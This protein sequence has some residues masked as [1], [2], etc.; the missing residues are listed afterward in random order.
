MRGGRDREAREE[1]TQFLFQ[2]LYIYNITPTD[3]LQFIC[4]WL[5]SG[6]WPL[7]QKVNQIQVITYHG[8]PYRSGGG[9][10]PGGEILGMCSPGNIQRRLFCSREHPLAGW[11]ACLESKPSVLWNPFSSLS[12]QS[13]WTTWQR[14]ATKE[15]KKRCL[16]TKTTVLYFVPLFTFG[17]ELRSCEKY[18][19]VRN[20]ARQ[21]DFD[22]SS[23]GWRMFKCSQESWTS[24]GPF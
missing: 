6:T 18:S 13:V 11:L 1:D 5:S 24:R 9:S 20:G 3:T 23:C 7:S 22:G 19:E 16:V 17:A 4:G 12:T 15:Y 14:T 10:N 2:R 8:P 21:C